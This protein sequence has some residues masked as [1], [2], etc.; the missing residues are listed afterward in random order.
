MKKIL[1]PILLLL[2]VAPT[3]TLLTSCQNEPLEGEF[4]TNEEEDP[5]EEEPGEEEP[6]E[7]EP[8][9]P[10]GSVVLLRRVEVTEGAINYTLN[11]F[12]NSDR[13]IERITKSNGTNKEYLYDEGAVQRV[14]FSDGSFYRYAHEEGMVS[15]RRDFDANESLQERQVY[16]FNTD[17]RISEIDF[18]VPED[19][20]YVVKDVF[21]YD[22]NGNCTSRKNEITDVS[23]NDTQ[24]DYTY[25]ERKNPFMDFTPNIVLIDD[26][27]SFVNNPLTEVMYVI[28][29]NET[30][31]FREHEYEYNES[32]YPTS[33][34]SVDEDENVV[35]TISYE[36]Y[37]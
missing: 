35:Q 37:Q 24:T 32:G 34:T 6:G 18:Y 2:L 22:E 3:T 13:Q 23:V 20:N 25:D 12:Y 19:N 31:Y 10:I 30:I 5:E 14:V 7:E 15:E 4:G 9:E 21:T 17:E 8:E 16:H 26:I 28:D 29:D 36:Y 1:L 33:R 11:F 27:P